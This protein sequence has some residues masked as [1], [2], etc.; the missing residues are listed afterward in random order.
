MIEIKN[1]SIGYKSKKETTLVLEGINARL[2]KRKLT[3]FLGRNGSGKSTL[4]KT[5]LGVLEPVSGDVFIEGKSLED[6]TAIDR[7]RK[8]SAVLTDVV[9]TEHISVFEFIALGRT[10][11][12]NWRGS[13]SDVDFEKVE[14]AISI[15]EVDSIRDKII[16]ELSDGQLQKVNIARAICQDTDLI[17]LDEPTAHLDVSN[18][19]KVFEI[20]RK[21]AIDFNKAI[22][23]ITHDLELAFQNSDILWVI[24]NEGELLSDV[25]EDLLLNK[26]VIESFLTSNFEFDYV[27]GKF[28]YKRESRIS[29]VL[30]GDDEGIYWTKQALYKNGY[31]ISDNSTYTLK[32]DGDNKQW[33]LNDG[34]NEIL[35]STS[36]KKLISGLNEIFFPEFK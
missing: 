24:D 2:E 10:P 3:C 36:I 27:S 18:K 15:C 1:L 25:T 19:F 22:F 34:E 23:I 16:N 30:E 13:L 9:R 12:T 35:Q 14:E 17:L 5:L 33:T 28:L 6:I 7:A 11:H 8:I 20:L 21:L 32:V 4:L 31:G 29:F 26:K